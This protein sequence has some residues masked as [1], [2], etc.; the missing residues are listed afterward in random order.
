MKQ[1]CLKYEEVAV[2]SGNYAKIRK[3]KYVVHNP[4]ETTQFV[5]FSL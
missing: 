4:H 5:P 1:I 3:F 2:E